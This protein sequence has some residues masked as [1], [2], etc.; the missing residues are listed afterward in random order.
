MD[1]VVKELG[2]DSLWST[3]LSFIDLS[4]KM[5]SVNANWLL[6]KYANLLCT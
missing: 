1:Y 3:S 2:E 6:K 5:L 4:G